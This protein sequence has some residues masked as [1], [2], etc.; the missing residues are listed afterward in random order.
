MTDGRRLAA[1]QP[2]AKLQSVWQVMDRVYLMCGYLAAAALAGIFVITMVQIASRLIGFNFRGATAYAGYLMAAS[3]FLA[4][5]H[6]FNHGSQIRI[7]LFQSMAG[8]Y[9]VVLDYFAFAA[10]AFV[11]CWLSYYCWQTV[12]WSYSFGDLSQELDAT[13][14]W[15]PQASMAFGMT[16]LAVAVVDHGVR[17]LITGDHQIKAAPDAL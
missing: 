9:R 6:T 4:F 15:I 17:L 16:L 3:A 14:L 11:A 12:Y 5:A 10:S 1:A 8:R 7:E 2:V 13:P